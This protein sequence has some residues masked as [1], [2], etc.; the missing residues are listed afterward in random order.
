VNKPASQDSIVGTLTRLRA[1]GPRIVILFTADA[2]DSAPLHGV[3][4]YF[5]VILRGK[6]AGREASTSSPSCSGVK[7]L[8]FMPLLPRMP[9]CPT[10]GQLQLS[11]L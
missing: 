5:G 9:L 10:D 6:V 2:R 3:R 11:P 7:M 1:V 4:T 8:R